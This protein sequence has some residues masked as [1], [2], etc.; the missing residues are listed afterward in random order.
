MTRTFEHV[1]VAKVVLFVEGFIL[2]F[3]YFDIVHSLHN[4]IYVKVHLSP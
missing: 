3:C 1:F 4:F 2:V